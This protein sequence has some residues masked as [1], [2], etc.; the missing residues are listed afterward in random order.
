M[1]SVGVY[2]LE[3]LRQ[4]VRREGNVHDVLSAR[5]LPRAREFV[6]HKLGEMRFAASPP[7]SPKVARGTPCKTRVEAHPLLL[8]IRQL[9]LRQ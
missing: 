8:R 4:D 3:Q 5:A 6:I 9:M 7:T 1:E 2:I